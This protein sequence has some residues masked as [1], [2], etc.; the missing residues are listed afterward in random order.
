MAKRSEKASIEV[1][2]RKLQEKHA[3]DVVNWVAACEE[4]ANKNVPKKDWPKKPVRPLK[5]KHSSG[6]SEIPVASSSAV[7]LEDMAQDGETESEDS[8]EEFES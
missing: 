8:G 6:A 1:E 7:T 5:P 4:L 2:W 3:K